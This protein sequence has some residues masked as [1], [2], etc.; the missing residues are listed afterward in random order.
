MRTEL[1][2]HSKHSL[3]RQCEIARKMEV[4][5]SVEDHLRGRPWSEAFSV[6]AI[7]ATGTCDGSLWDGRVSHCGHLA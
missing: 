3:Q 4:G 7:N 5:I 2:C 1:G 6:S